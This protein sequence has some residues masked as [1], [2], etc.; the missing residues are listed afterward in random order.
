MGSQRV[1]H[2]W[3]TSL[4]LSLV[5][6]SQLPRVIHIYSFLKCLTIGLSLIVVSACSRSWHVSK[7][8]LWIDQSSHL[9][10]YHFSVYWKPLS[11]RINCTDFTI[12]LQYL[13]LDSLRLFPNRKRNKYKLCLRCKDSGFTLNGSFQYSSYF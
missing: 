10:T 7:W 6:I 2:D 13:E 5:M 4:S 12:L 8:I 11:I 9:C 1:G 3:A